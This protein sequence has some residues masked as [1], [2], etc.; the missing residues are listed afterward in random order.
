MEA[1]FAFLCE[2]VRPEGGAAGDRLT[3]TGFPVTNILI[4]EYAP[5]IPTTT[6]LVGITYSV[7][8]AGLKDVDLRLLAPDGPVAGT[9]HEEEFS[10]PAA[11]SRGRL[12]LIYETHP[13]PIDEAGEYEFSLH[14]GYE[15]VASVPFTVV[16]ED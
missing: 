9:R 6:L 7:D 12:A 8:E 10:D 11:G 3:I 16:R 2:G 1:Q 4:S 5:V 15:L 13:I 14:V